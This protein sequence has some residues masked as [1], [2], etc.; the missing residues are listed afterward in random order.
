ML[1]SRMKFTEKDFMFI[2]ELLLDQAGISLNNDK[3]E[4]VYSRLARRLRQLG[5]EDFSDY[6]ELLKEK[7]SREIEH[8]L[9]AIT[10]NHTSFFREDH[11]F[12]FLSN[13]LLNGH[14]KKAKDEG[15]KRRFRIWSA[16]CSSGEEPYSI[17]IT[18][19]EFG[20]DLAG[21]DVKILAADI[22]SNILEQAKAGVYRQFNEKDSVLSGRRRW[23][24]KG[25]GSNEGLVK[26]IPEIRDMVEFRKMNLKGQWSLEE[27]FDVIFCR[28][29]MIY[30]DK[31]IKIQIFKNFASSLVESGHLI[32][33]HSESLNQLSSDF[34]ALGGT[35]HRKKK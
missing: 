13:V 6:C 21:W 24:Q 25:K 12:K 30:F 28:N 32:V 15:G 23:F 11:H 29:V 33:G 20:K 8:C 5:L 16:G 18:V 3:S 14:V 31:E 1:F 7:N 34:I 22:D 35:I 17:A 2:K 4:L 26:V 9:N 27:K 19:K 10:T